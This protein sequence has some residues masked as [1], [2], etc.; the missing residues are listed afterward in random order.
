MTK[1]RTESTFWMNG[2]SR[3]ILPALI[4]PSLLLFISGCSKGGGTGGR[5]SLPPTPVEVTQAKVQKVVDKFEAVGTIEASEAITVV[6]EI[7]GAVVSLPFE[8]GSFIKRGEL[9]ARLDDSQ[10]AAEVARAEALHAQS[11]VNYE[12]VKAVVEQK[13]GTPQDLDDA[14]AG[15]KVADANLALAKARFAKTR[16]VA[17]F[18]GIIGARRVSVGSYIRAGQAITELANIDAIRVNFSAPERFLSKLTRGAEVTVS[19]TAF[20]GYEVKGTII[21]I[22]PVLDPETR[23]ARIVARVPNP[24]RK[25]RPGMSADVS[26]VL[27]ERSNAITVPNEA[28]FASGNQSFVFVVKP[29]STATRV[30]ITLGT[31]LTDV[32]EVVQ[33]LEPGSEV[34]KA[35]H[36]KLYEG[37]KVMPMATQHGGPTE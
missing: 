13:A 7:D 34:V 30:P 21:A 36:Q 2:V 3:R 27:S 25:F 12:R 31:R 4:V 8:E 32:V 33:G 17:P 26:A 35:G 15:L 19:T 29:D 14:A 6:S 5:F 16:I 22:E 9:I 24:A 11:H 1:R 28:V 20:P 37:A 18:D 10:L 23:N